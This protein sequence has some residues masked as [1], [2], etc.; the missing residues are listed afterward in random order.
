MRDWLSQSFMAAFVLLG[1]G[2]PASAASNAAPIC[3]V[4]SEAKKHVGETVRF[5]GVYLTDGI[6]RAI[7][8]PVGC[9]QSF[10]IGA[11]PDDVAKSLDARALPGLYPRGD[12]EAVFTGTI[13]QDAPNGAQF[14]KD[15][16]ARLNVI[17]VEDVKSKSR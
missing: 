1:F 16:G 13:V 2:N 9:R 7:V 15:D 17:K 12:V 10:A 6:E 4:A 3:R 5:R 11:I 14:F 8:T